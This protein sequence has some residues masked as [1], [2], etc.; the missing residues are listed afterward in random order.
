MKMVSIPN[1]GLTVSRIAY[2]CMKLASIQAVPA[3]LPKAA[4]DVCVAA[5][6]EG[7][8]FFDHA[9]I[10]GRGKCEELFSGFWKQVPRDQIILQTKC[11]IRPRDTPETGEPGRYD[12]S[13]EHIIRTVEASLSR[14]KTD[15]LDILLLH[16]PDALVSPEEV[17]R[18]F[19]ELHG[20]G[21]VRYFGIS[22][23]N[24]LQIELLRK[25]VKQPLVTNQLQLS[26]LHHYLVSEGVLV[27]V[28]GK[29]S[30]LASGTLDYCRLHGISVQAWSP[31]ARGIPLN[32]PAEAPQHLKDLAAY[33]KRLADGKGTTPEAILLAWILRHPANIIPIIGTV[34]VAHIKGSIQ[35][36]KVSLTREEWY[37]MLEFARGESVP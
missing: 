35:A 12:F 29:P 23:H 3:D 20:A 5:Y 27:N 31:V 14:L 18:A 34:N 24:V 28:V 26:I 37:R 11:G 36:D 16:R 10:Y 22:N 6:N 33:V 13:F 15:Y 1:T 30:V 4:V 25:F 19:N 8:N 17:D 2:G 9:D 32:P 21:K 7:I